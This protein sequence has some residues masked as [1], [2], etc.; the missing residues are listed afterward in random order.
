L[1][2]DLTTAMINATVEIDQPQSDGKRIVG[3][4]FLI[5]DP[6]PDGTPRTVLITAGHVFNN[7]SGPSARIGYRFQ[8]ADGTWRYSAQPVDIRQGASQL[9]VRNPGQDIAAISIQAPPEFAKAAIPIA[10]LADESALVQ[11]QVAPGDEM[12]VLGYPEGYASNTDGFP[13]LRVGRVASYPLT[14][15]H[16]FQSFLLD[17]RVFNGNSGSPVFMTAAA[18]RHPGAPDQSN[19]LV[20]GIVTSQTV[21]GDERL[22]LGI[23]IQAQYIKDT[24]KLLDQPASGAA[25]SVTAAS[26]TS[27]ARPASAATPPPPR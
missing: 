15:T 8:G 6:K 25:T 18:R 16:E 9:W 17:F 20:A 14:P 19:P 13:I 27:V 1:A 7:M 24:L 22:G 12:F 3:T 10:W 26:A 4:G 11:A 2:I 5:D 21:V 23:V